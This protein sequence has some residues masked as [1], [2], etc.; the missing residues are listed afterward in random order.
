MNDDDEA[1]LRDGDG[2]H[3][4]VVGGEAVGA[5]TVA[6]RRSAG[7]PGGTIQRA[8]PVEAE[9]GEIVSPKRGVGR[10]KGSRNIRTELVAVELI[11]TFGD[12]LEADMAMGTM[13]PGALVTLL[14]TIA[15]DRGIKM[16]MSL[17]DVLRLQADCRGRALPYMHAKRIAVDD[18]GHAVTPVIAFGTFSGEQQAVHGRSIEDIGNDEQNQELIDITQ[19]KSD[20]DKSDDAP[21]I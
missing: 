10:P 5:G 11:E 19:S 16:G 20:D 1:V 9:A 21:S 4:G 18:K 8:L 2:A 14:R 7:A 12:P 6:T 3:R 13:A 15:S 17:M